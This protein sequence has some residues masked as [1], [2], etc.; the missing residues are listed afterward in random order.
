M[1][2]DIFLQAFRDG[3]GADADAAVLVRMLAPF[4]A[5]RGEGWA[6][7][8]FLDGEADVYGLDHLASGVMI[9]H[10]S[11]RLVWNLMFEMAQGAGLTIWPV[12]C[13]AAVTVDS[14]LADLPPELRSDAV[15]VRSGDDHP[16]IG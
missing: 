9:N 13:P 11:G 2:F 14:A 6:L 15:V 16:S 12:G 5:D 4:I 10:A 1:S 3:E 8:R 7:L